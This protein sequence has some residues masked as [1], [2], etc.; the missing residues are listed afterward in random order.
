MTV[1]KGES[2]EMIAT[3]VVTGWRVC[4]DYRMLNAATRKDHFPLP[5]ID[6][7]L[8]RLA[9]C[10]MAIFHD[11]IES[12]MEVFMDDFSVFG[13]SFDHCLENLSVVLARCEETNLVLNWEKCHFMVRE[14]IVLGHKVSAAG[15]EVDRAKIVAIEKLPPPTNDRAVR[16]FLGHAGFYRRFI[17]DFSK[18]AKPLSQL[19]EKDV[20]FCFDDAC[21]AAFE[22]LKKVLVTA[23]VLIV[24][25]W[26]QPF[27]LMC[28]ASDITIGA[29]LGQKRDKIFHVIYY[30]SRTLD[31]AQVNYTVTEKEM[32]AVVYAFDKFRAYLIG[33]KSQPSDF[34]LTRRMPSHDSFENPVEG[35]ELQVPIKETFPDEQIL[36]VSSPTPWYADYVNFL[37][38]K[39]PP[40][41]DLS[42]YKKKKFYHDVKFY[43]WEK[44]FLYR[45]CADMVIR[46]CVPEEEWG[47][48]LTQ[49]HSSPSGGHFGANRTTFKVLQ[50]GFYWP[51]IF[52]DAHAFI[53]RCDRC[54]RMGG[55]SKRHEMPLTS[56]VEVEL[57]DVWGIDF[58][59]PF[60]SSYGNQYILLAVEYVSR[61]VEA[62][63]T[64]KNDSKV[65]M[66]FLQKYILSR[67]GAPRALV[68]GGGS[69]FCNRW[70]DNLLK[71]NGVKHRVTTAYHPQ[72]NGQTE[73]ANR[74]IKQ[75]L[76]KTVNGGHKDWAILLDDALWAYRTAYKTPLGM[77]P[78]QLVFGKSC[79]LP[80]EFTHKAFWA[81]KKLNLDFHSAGKERMLHLSALEEF[82]DQAFE[83]SSI[84]KE[85][86]KRFHDKMILKREFAVGD[87]VLLFNSHLRLFPG[88]LKSKWSGPFTI[89]QVFPNGTIELS[90]ERGEPF[91][92]NGQRVKAYYSPD[93]VHTV[94]V[95]DL[96]DC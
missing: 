48:I 81:V 3:R 12:V 96:H 28:D 92:V 13:S 8:D 6:Q 27:E 52:K 61:W 83:N 50:S 88:K 69:H 17:K 34:S 36:Q 78:Y 67:Y 11:L 38:A 74:E 33:I 84:Y 15:L 9:G 29:A 16:S 72:A 44:P 87:Q 95:I 80:V 10:M 55:I 30:A 73:L 47:P 94:D 90:K 86:T 43:M 5:F 49:C 71:R 37:A 89:S 58:M 14:S 22:T 60:P 20:K 32:L 68:S 41:K 4:I 21:T 2:D 19:L 24:P 85:R 45:R 63:P 42:T 26:T 76:E 35:E 64:A 79:H 40:P 31:K 59:G 53:S 51:S 7:M 46:R 54:Q 75:V 66:K 1:V 82:R 65:V 91:R 70:L 77:S 62:I 25:D 23:P 39:Y 93:Q 57:F 56:V 18:V